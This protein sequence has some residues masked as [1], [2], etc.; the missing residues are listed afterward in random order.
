MRLVA[1][2]IGQFRKFDRPV[3]IE[4]FSAGMNVLCGP[5]EFGKSTIL[6]AIRGLLFE[7]HNSRAEPIKRMQTRGGN[8][9]P[10]LA[11]EFDISGG[12][13]RIEKRF[14]HQPAALLTAPS[15]ARFEGEAAEEE[16]QRLLGFGAPGNKGARPEHMGVW[17]ALWVTQRES[18]AQADLTSDLART[19]IT[20]CLD[21]EVGVLTGSEKGQALLRAA[22]EQLGVLLDGNG[23]PKGRYRQLALDITEQER[24]LAGLQDRARRLTEDAEVLR[25]ETALLAQ[26]ADAESEA[27]DRDALADARRRREAA[28][29]HEQRLGAART[30][31]QLAER[32]HAEALREIA[33]RAARAQAMQADAAAAAAATR[34]AEQ[35]EAAAAEADAAL[36]AARA[37][38]A[39]GEARAAAASRSSA[40]ARHLADIGRTADLLAAQ[41]RTLD[42]AEAAQARVNALRARLQAIR[43]DAP[44][45]AA[46]RRA[47]REA[48]TARATLQAQAT[49]VEFELRPGAPVSIAGA[50]P[51]GRVA[52]VDDTDIMVDGVGRIRIR[53][54]IRDRDKLGRKLRAA[55]D[56][57]REALAAGDCAEAEA[58]ETQWAAREALEAQ[59]REAEAEL[60]RAAPGDPAAKLPPGAHALRD[61]VDVLRRR[62][63]DGLAA[64]DLVA[65]PPAE[66]VEAA[67][68]EA[69]AEETAAAEALAGARAA[70]D[71]A[72]SRRADARE[73][74]VRAGEAAKAASRALDRLRD[75]AEAA[76]AREPA[77]ALAA[78]LEAAETARVAAGS[79]LAALERSP[80]ADSVAAMQARIERYDQALAARA[81][82]VRRLRE[83]I[84][85]LRA[86][87]AQEGGNGLDEQIAGIERTLDALRR[88]Q[89]HCAQEVAVLRLL[90]DTLAEAEREAKE[91]YL[92]PV[93]R[94]VSPY[95]RNLFP[96]A[97]IACDDD[98]RITGITRDTLGA[99]EFDRLSDGTQEQ[100]AV[101]ARLAF[102]EMLIDQGKP[103]M[104]IL[105][106][107]LAYSDAD[108]MERMFDILTQ[109]A[110]KTQVLVLTCRADIFARLGGT[111]LEVRPAVLAQV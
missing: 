91:R 97:E 13:W 106:D 93:I 87:I 47:A 58:A 101:L 90:T 27:R 45:I 83:S 80:P 70:L 38:L 35:A 65:P 100:M 29:L 48:E 60:V 109:A 72:G 31:L 64:L 111:R 50:A 22:R 37:A 107:A 10:V 67:A 61:L 39:E 8:A 105:D 23:K 33:A 25:R 41:A 21:A 17:G 2:E 96:G 14:L 36:A 1:L 94:R 76:E 57:L 43:L 9:A 71:G 110:A 99:E 46:I 56:A 40:R 55:E 108:R 92:A 42:A 49:L 68:R 3:R 62:L 63:A 30:A 82:D 98:L 34:R 28:L 103:A 79:T 69:A 66:L 32:E 78:R 26:R 59:L 4:G 95:L 19:T 81:Q 5:N 84:A 85:A 88:E 7:R 74:M 52:L 20:G 77:D 12:T 104:V 11:M 86:R 53:P 24:L 75:E 18:V 6:A 54:A 89:A 51:P 73:A 102:A 15:G 44:G 16:L